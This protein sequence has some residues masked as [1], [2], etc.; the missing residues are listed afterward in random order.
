MHT[1]G[2]RM[3]PDVCCWS[4][5]GPTPRPEQVL[6]TAAGAT[7]TGEDCRSMILL[8][9]EKKRLPVNAMYYGE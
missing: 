9:R 8:R 1:S 2:C 6:A 4:G 5:E 3:Y 7:T